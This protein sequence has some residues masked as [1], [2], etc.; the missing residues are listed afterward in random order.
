MFGLH[1]V[2]D[3]VDGLYTGKD[4]VFQSHFV[5]LR[6]YRSGELIEYL[7]ALH[8][9]GFQFLFYL[10]VLFRMFV[11]EAQVFQFCLDFVQ[12]EAVGERGINIE[13]F[14]CN[15]ELF[16]GQHGAECTH[17]MQTV[18]YLDEDNPDIVGHSEQQL[19]EVL[20][21][22][23][24]TVAEDTA[25]NLCQPVY[26]LGDF[27]TE[28]VFDILYGVVSVFHHIVQQ[29]R[30]YGSRPQS[31]LITDNLC[32]SNGVH[33]VGLAGTTLD[34]LMR[35]VGKVECFG[36]YFDALAVF[37]GQIVVQQFLECLFD[38]F[39]FGFFLFLLTYIFFHILLSPFFTSLFAKISNFQH[40]ASVY[41][42]IYKSSNAFLRRFWYYAIHSNFL[43][44]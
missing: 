4:T 32:H 3:G 28:D 10:V 38:H 6:P 31:Y 41:V 44:D 16:V 39:L 2:P 15:L 12:A 18:G 5:Q 27:G 23:R 11:L 35:L 20:R 22:R 8:S 33:D 9:G 34:A 26:N 7:V 1:F 42:F 19:L 24:G 17:V 14:A 43:T 13:C 29:C 36:Y 37:G 25:G 30:A 40:R 21:L